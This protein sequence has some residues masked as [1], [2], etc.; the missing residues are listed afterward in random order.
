M[1]FF[2]TINGKLSES[3]HSEV[4][5]YI[6]IQII[7]RWDGNITNGIKDVSIEENVIYL[8][9]Y[10]SS[11]NRISKIE[12]LKRGNGE[13]NNAIRKYGKISEYTKIRLVKILY[14]L[15]VWYM[16]SK[17]GPF[18]SRVETW[19]SVSEMKCYRKLL[20]IT[21]SAYTTNKSVLVE[22]RIEDW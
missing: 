19:G 14:F 22:L 17:H 20:R 10:R 6:N 1:F 11:R 12:Q 18:V 9:I 5:K 7:V 2:I 16:D 21:W 13:I 15:K 4:N 3:F 8:E